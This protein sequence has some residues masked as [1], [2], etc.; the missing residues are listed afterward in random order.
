MKYSDILKQAK[1]LKAS[2]EKDQKFNINSKYIYYICKAIIKQADVKHID[3]DKAPNPSGNYVSR[4]VYKTEYMRM[5]KHL[6]E[7]VEKKGRLPNFI[8]TGDK[9]VRVR[10]YG[11]AFARILIYI[12]THKEYPKYVNINSKAYTKTTE[13]GDEIYNYFCKVFGKVTCIDDALEYIAGKGYGYYYDDVYSNRQSIDRIKKGQGVNCTDATQMMKHVADGTGK[14]KAV[15]CIHVKCRGGDGHVF[16]RI[17][18]KTGQKFYRDPAAVLDSGNI[19]RIWCSDGTILTINP[20]W[21]LA[22]LNK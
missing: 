12:D 19:S 16:L 3:F 8:K 18:T 10:D 6:I 11:Y 21:W 14:Y 4:S 22:N 5:V 7:F 1:S 20:S 17:T 9:N 13:T 15:D 2:V